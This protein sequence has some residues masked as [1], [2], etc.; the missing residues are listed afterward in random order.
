MSE[1]TTAATISSAA[2]GTVTD[3][4]VVRDD[5]GA[6]ARQHTRVDR[7]FYVGV[8]M[9]V[10][11]L[12]IAGFGPSLL[13]RSMRHDRPSPLVIIHGVVASAWLLLFLVQA[14]LVA[15]GRTSI[16]RRLGAIAPALMVVM[17]VLVFQ[18]TIEMVRRGYDLSGDLFRTAAAPRAPVPPVAEV[19]GGLGAFVSAVNF[20]ILV[21]AGWWYRRRPHIHKRLMLVALLSLAVIPLLHLGGYVVGRWPALLWPLRAL[22]LAGNLLLFAGAVHDKI[23]SGRVHPISLW[24]PLAIIVVMLCTLAV[25]L[26]APWRQFAAWLAG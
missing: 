19:D 24:V 20:G 1:R 5:L 14:V 7:W 11:L 15:R 18:T 10:I 9:F 22:P 4:S 25:S 6:H 2:A 13:E 3:Q 12:H 21:A 26:S 23:T 17:V 8:A 16:H